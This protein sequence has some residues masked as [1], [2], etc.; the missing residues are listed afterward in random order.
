MSDHDHQLTNG[1]RLVRPQPQPPSPGTGH[2]PVPEPERRHGGRPRDERAHQLILDATLALLWEVGYA[3]MTIEG[4]AAHAGVG[5]TTIY[6]RWPSKGALV[7]EAISGPICPIATGK[8]TIH[9][10]PL[11]DTGSLRNDLLTFVERVN[12]AFTA[13]LASRTLPGLAADLATDSDLARAYREAVVRP[14]RLRIAEVLQ[15]ATARGELHALA[16]VDLVCDLL[17]GPL[18]YRSMLTGEGLDQA[19]AEGLV[20]NVLRGLGIA[21]EATLAKAGAR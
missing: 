9:L 14:K 10:G 21:P 20:D 4:V 3:A 6:R 2:A 5:K 11:P 7:V 12:Y 15:R 13:P 8:W 17:V 1:R 16:D 18:L 19:T